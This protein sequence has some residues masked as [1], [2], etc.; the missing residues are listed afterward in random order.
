MSTMDETYTI[1]CV[2]ARGITPYLRREVEA[3]G[4]TIT[5]ELD[6]GVEIEGT[7]P[8]TLQLNLMLR[9]AIRIQVELKRF[10]AM[11]ADHLYRHVRDIPWESYIGP[12]DYLTVT[13]Y[14][15]NDSIRDFRFVNLKAKDAIVDRIRREYGSR[16]DAGKE[17]TGVVVF[18]YWSGA[19]VTVYLETSGEPLSK[20]GYRKQPMDAPMQEA[21]AA[22]VV[23][24]TGWTG[25]GC[26]VNPM[27]GSG[28]LA[29]EAALLARGTAPGLNRRDYAFLQIKDF[30][31]STFP[32]LRKELQAHRPRPCGPIIATD[33]SPAAIDAARQNAENAGVAD[34]IDFRVCDFADTPVPE[35][36]GVVVFNPPYGERMGD[37]DELEPLYRSIG[38]YFKTQC[39][40]K[41]GFIFTGNMTLAK[42]IGLRSV[43]RV[44]FWNARIESRLLAFDIY[45]GSR[46]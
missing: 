18:I 44:P 24:D 15:N 6:T 39:Q 8:D 7:I 35:G 33:I 16:P 40:G 42:R 27:C 38:D 11:N 4:Y 12:H 2:C 10:R 30:P 19:D 17:R 21:L 20:R 45:E 43:R 28:T 26:F 13:S 31:R 14:V 32:T 25:E 41:M 22:A 36:P 29:I 34:C 3:L 9:T 5:R 37:A 46:H 1:L 23:M